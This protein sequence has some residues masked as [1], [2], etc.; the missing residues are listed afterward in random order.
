MDINPAVTVIARARL[1]S[2]EY[3]IEL[4]EKGHEILELARDLRSD[5]VD[6][7]LL[8]RWIRLDAVGALRS[9]QRAIHTLCVDSRKDHHLTTAFQREDLLSNEAC[10][11][12]ATLFSVTRDVLRRF[13]ATNPMW[14]KEPESRLH[15]VHPSQETLY[16]KYSEHNQR[17]VDKLTLSKDVVD[18]HSTSLFTGDVTKFKFDQKSFDGAVTSPPYA[19]RL[20]YIMGS[21]PELATLG[22]PV[23]A[24]S[25]LRKASVG[26]PLVKALRDDFEVPIVSDKAKLTLD[27]IRAHSSKGSHNYYMPWLRNYFAKLEFGLRSVS[28]AVKDDGTICVV[29]QDSFYKDEHINLQSITEEMMAHVDREL[30]QRF[31][32]EVSGI[33][34]GVTRGGN[35]RL[36]NQPT[37][38]LL[39]FT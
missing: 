27:K 13:R 6:E 15:R 19:T 21:L 24:V 34:Y 12:Y 17:L 32:F 23:E 18:S 10:L 2:R 25:N 26:T 31:D 11:F 28:N 4:L 7:D 20:D 3:R 33:R 8:L 37:E 30:I 1:L 35:T 29:V 22:A 39:V 38:T 14:V 9:I 5:V 36:P 16:E